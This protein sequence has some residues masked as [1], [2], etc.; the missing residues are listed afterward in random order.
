MAIRRTPEQDGEWLSNANEPPDG[1]HRMSQ[2][3]FE[4]PG[5]SPVQ[6]DANS[7]LVEGGNILIIFLK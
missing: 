7:N 2:M 5:L 1:R 3:E 4:L 6:R